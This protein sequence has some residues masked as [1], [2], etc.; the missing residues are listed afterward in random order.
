MNYHLSMCFGVLICIV[1]AKVVNLS[2]LLLFVLP[3]TIC[4]HLV[5]Q[6]FFRRSLKTAISTPHKLL[7]LSYTILNP[8]KPHAV[9]NLSSNS[10]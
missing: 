2:E 6:K 4:A 7:K 3:A 1:F 10:R 9:T 8:L 5:S